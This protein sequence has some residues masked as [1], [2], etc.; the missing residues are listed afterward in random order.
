MHTIF[1]RKSNFPEFLFPNFELPLPALESEKKPS[2]PVN[3]TEMKDSL[4]LE[5]SIPGFRKEEITLL[6]DEGRNLKIEGKPSPVNEP[7]EGIIRK[8][9][10]SLEPFTK[11][12][13]LGNGLNSEEIKAS[14]ENGLLKISIAKLKKHQN[15]S[16]RQ[17]PLA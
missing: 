14:V 8:K 3:V 17:I 9:M 7:N 6:V 1:H 10:F 2:L 4:E 5:L 11:K 16:V 12:Y 15:D 13:K